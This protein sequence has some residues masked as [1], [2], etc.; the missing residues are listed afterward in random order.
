MFNIGIE[1]YLEYCLLDFS[2]TS[3]FKNLF[4]RQGT[5]KSLW[6][7]DSRCY[8]SDEREISKR[9]FLALVEE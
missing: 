8:C 1:K 3:T 4:R 2:K 7:L 9:G 6:T 5:V